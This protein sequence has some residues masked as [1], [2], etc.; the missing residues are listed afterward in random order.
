VTALLAAL[1]L[2]APPQFVVQGDSHIG[3]FAVKRD[4]TLAGLTRVFGRPTALRRITTGCRA[5]WRSP[6]MTVDLYNLGGG[7][8]CK[9]FHHAVLTGS[10]WRTA[11]GLRIGDSSIR[12]RRLFPRAERHGVWLW[13]IPRVYQVGSYRYAGLS[14]K[15]A[16]GRV[17]ALRVEYPA[18]GD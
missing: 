8:R 1:A 17:R 10:Q 13:L 3:S 2:S 12:A 16:D 6:A 18:G 5:T 4:G 14:A 9:F 7:D 11:K 15:I